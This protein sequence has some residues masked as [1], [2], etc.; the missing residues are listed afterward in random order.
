MKKK[1][2]S[3]QCRIVVFRWIDLWTRN[4]SMTNRQPVTFWPHIHCRW[5]LFDKTNRVFVC[6]RIRSWKGEKKKQNKTTAPGSK[7]EKSP[8]LETEIIEE[9]TTGLLL[10]R[11]YGKIRFVPLTGG[12]SAENQIQWWT[13]DRPTNERIYRKHG[14]VVVLLFFFHFNLR[15]FSASS[16]GSFGF[17]LSVCAFTA[18]NFPVGLL[19]R[20]EKKKRARTDR[21]KKKT[22]HTHTHSH[23]KLRMMRRKSPAAQM[24]VVS[25][26]PLAAR[27]S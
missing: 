15:E 4:N 18:C 13:I 14:A 12:S 27:G 16:L 9:L 20:M 6:F 17:F 7:G 1:S 19:R 11:H 24:P 2:V 22:K 5:R 8:A 3:N 25:H 26:A 21:K 23:G 10:A